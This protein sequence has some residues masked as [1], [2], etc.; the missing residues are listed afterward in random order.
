[1]N[2]KKGCSLNKHR[3]KYE[4][5]VELDADSGPARVVRLVGSNRSVLEIGAGPGSITKIL[6]SVSNCKVTAL[7]IDFESI[8]KLKPYCERAYQA[9]LNDSSWPNILENDGKF[10]VLVA[11]D[12]LEHVYE[13]LAVL[14]AMNA[15]L[16][17]NG[18]MVISLPH[19]GHSVVHACLFDEDFEYNDFGLLD[20]THIRFFG[21]KNIQ[22]LFQ[23]AG[24]KIVHAEFVI[25]NPEHTEF[26]RTWAKTPV[27]F[28]EALALNPFGL[29]Y[30][31]IVKAVPVSGEGLAI[32]LMDKLIT[33]QV[34][35]LKQKV[36][37]L[38]RTHLN[39]SI[40]TKLKK[41]LIR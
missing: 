15:F 4:Y 22:K 26:A 16:N 21:I 41:A 27:L 20:R 19:A 12:V 32:S 25:R 14:K 2:V 23:D 13:P 33:P 8:E 38:L 18:F 37:S 11:A 39:E 29:V 30:Q 17:Q 31:V 24:M 35:T 34:P 3:H 1:M 9:D 6:T 28:R 10:D 7:D 36:K 40:Y 5:K